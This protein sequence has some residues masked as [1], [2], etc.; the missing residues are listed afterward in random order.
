MR[1]VSIVGKCAVLLEHIMTVSSNALHHHCVHPTDVRNS[2]D[3]QTA[4]THLK[5]E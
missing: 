4:Q 2:I 3:P 1:L 5:E